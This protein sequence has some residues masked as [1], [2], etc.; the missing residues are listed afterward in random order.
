MVL[1]KL[2]DIDQWIDR[3]SNGSVNSL[4][5]DRANRALDELESLIDSYVSE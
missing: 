2:R 5:A 4:P 1:E 3:W